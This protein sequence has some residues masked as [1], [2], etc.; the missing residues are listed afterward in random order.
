MLLFPGNSAASSSQL[1]MSF[2]DDGVVRVGVNLDDG[3]ITA[4]IVGDD[5]FGVGIVE[6]MTTTIVAIP[7]TVEATEYPWSVNGYLA[8]AEPEIID[9][10]AVY[11]YSYSLVV[12][13]LEGI[14]AYAVRYRIDGRPDYHFSHD[15]RHW[16]YVNATDRGFPI[17]GA[18]RVNVD[19]RDP[20]LIGPQQSWRARSARTLYV[21][22]AWHT[23]QDDA[24]LFWSV[25]DGGFSEARSIRFLARNDGRF[26]T[27]KLRV[28]RVPTYGGVI[29]QL[30][31]DP[32]Q[33]RDPGWADI[34][35]ISWKP[36]RPQPAVERALQTEGRLVP[37]LDSRQRHRA[38]VSTRRPAV[39]R[40]WRQRHRRR[41]PAS[42]RSRLGDETVG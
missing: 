9:A 15:R 28:A 20:Q 33:G 34:E 37:Y 6:P 27:Y 26:H 35:C 10:N 18:L 29:D 32:V 41:R 38:F 8:P 36:C 2:L 11:S 3:K 19:E 4:A 30:R 16:W 39:N 21:R 25:P 24:Q 1:G 23:A 31:L 40:E 7:G 13:S 42:A 5:G 17:N 12:G 14:R 22:G